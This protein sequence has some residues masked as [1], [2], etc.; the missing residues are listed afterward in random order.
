[1][2]AQLPG[3]IDPENPWLGAQQNADAIAYNLALFDRLMARPL[4][5]E[6]V[7]QDFTP[8]PE[9]YQFA[10]QG[11]S[12]YVGANTAQNIDKVVVLSA[13]GASLVLPGPEDL[14]VGAV[15]TT[16]A[17]Q[18]VA[19][20]IEVGGQK[21]LRLFDGAISN[22]S[23]PTPETG[24]AKASISLVYDKVE[25]VW[26]TPAG[27]DYGIGSVHGN[28]VKHVL[29]HAVPNPSKPK[30]TVFNV[31]RD[32][33]LALVDEAWRLRGQP[34]S[35]DPGSYVVSMNKVVGTTGETRIKIVVR[36]GTNK[37]ITAYPIK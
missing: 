6:V 14:A 32:Q 13:A 23:V 33:V 11:S 15:L 27:L 24:L 35:N 22:G 19:R 31:E 3:G 21:L 29:D 18:F 8:D 9:A 5:A 28:R 17:G 12:H 37:L 2:G 4:S 20:V 26:K 30:H 1:M 7:R 34:L 25:R 36:P 10:P 16:Q